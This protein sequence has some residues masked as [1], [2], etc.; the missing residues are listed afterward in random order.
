MQCL[1]CKLPQGKD[2]GGLEKKRKEQQTAAPA[3]AP[4]PSSLEPLRQ[5]RLITHR[6]QSCKP[7]E[8]SLREAVWE[9]QWENR[10]PHGAGK[11]G[12]TGHKTA[13]AQAEEK[14]EE[15]RSPAKGGVRALLHQGKFCGV[16]AVLDL[17][18]CRGSLPSQPGR[19]KGDSPAL[20]GNGSLALQRDLHGLLEAPQSLPWP[21]HTLRHVTALP[22][23]HR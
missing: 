19:T 22:K 16:Q 12:L 3:P 13:S 17:A 4:R 9:E 6:E 10:K 20:L 11:K 7:W 8:P 18:G 2:S 21:C 14:A 5:S 1:M 23:G 15:G